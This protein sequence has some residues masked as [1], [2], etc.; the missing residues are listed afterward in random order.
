LAA[1]AAGPKLDALVVS[2][3]LGTVNYDDLEKVVPQPGP[4]TADPLP[5]A[6]AAPAAP[7]ASAQA[8]N[9]VDGF[10]REV[11]AMGG[12]FSEA[13]RESSKATVETVDQY[14][15]H[16][17][18]KVKQGSEKTADGVTLGAH[19]GHGA[20]VKGGDTLESTA[21]ST[22]TAAHDGVH[23]KDAMLLDLNAKL[24]VLVAEIVENTIRDT[25]AATIAAGLANASSSAP[26]AAPAAVAP[27][28]LK[29]SFLQAPA[30][31]PAMAAQVVADPAAQ[32]VNIFVE[33]LPGAPK[34]IAVGAVPLT[35]APAPI[36]GDKRAHGTMIMRHIDPPNPNPTVGRE[37]RVQVVLTDTPATGDD[38]LPTIKQVLVNAEKSGLLQ[39]ALGAALVKSIG[40]R[41][42]V[43][44][45]AF[46]NTFVAQWSLES[47]AT[48]MTQVVHRFSVAY[49]RRM[50]PMAIFNE[51]T[52]FMPAMSFSHDNLPNSMD[53]H[54]CR[55][56]TIGFAKR[57]NY[58]QGNGTAPPPTG[59]AAFL[60][61][62]LK[63]PVDMHGF[64]VDVCQH[65]FGSLAPECHAEAHVE[66]GH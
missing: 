62:K 46:N 47:C 23:G 52:N 33:F 40:V 43:T 1:A 39:A 55:M 31:A 59:L 56:A 50:V 20:V 29:T 36:S 34:A 11:K 66:M 49:T 48:H 41:P 22:A 5:P 8:N 26:A 16:V 25:I 63:A 38:R 58:G 13:A 64:C 65:K 35:D 44:N 18:A 53:V 3:D 24:N 7:A 15:T 60:D 45:F 12:A 14:S 17:N 10:S 27:V 6:V 37:T 42:N 61:T 57:W 28:G 21:D 2:F 9:V 19:A 54:R 32:P 30:A 4:P 51:C